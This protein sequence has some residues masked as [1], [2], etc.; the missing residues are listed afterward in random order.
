MPLSTRIGFSVREA[1]SMR[2]LPSLMPSRYSPIVPVSGSF[3]R[4]SRMSF[5][6]SISLLPTLTSLVR[7]VPS[8]AERRTNS[9]TSPPLWQTTEF[10]PSLISLGSKGTKGIQRPFSL[11]VTPMQLGPMHAMD[12][13]RAMRTMPSSRL[14]LSAPNSEN[15]PV[16]ITT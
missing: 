11:F 2:R 13:L 14:F 1:R 5:S 10:F 9:C 4:N 7:P 16:S 6:S 8:A 3:M 12:H 15:P